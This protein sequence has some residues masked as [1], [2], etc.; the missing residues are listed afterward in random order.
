MVSLV[1]ESTKTKRG[2]KFKLSCRDQVLLW[3]KYIREYLSF[4]SVGIIFGVS[5]SAAY[6]VC[7]FVENVLI[8]NKSFH[9]PGKKELLKVKDGSIAIDVSESPVQRPTKKPKH[10]YSGKKKK[11]TI[12]N[13]ISVSTETKKILS[14]AISNCRQHDFKLFK[15]SKTNIHP[16]NEVLVDSGYQGITNFHSNSS[17]PKKNTKNK[18]LSKVDKIKNKKFSSKRIIVENVFAMLKR[19]KIIAEKY[20]NRR[21]RFALRFNLISAIYNLELA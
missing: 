21:K 13:Q 6:R 18:K 8:K 15:N 19:F 14:A 17:L 11:H 4:E 9:L 3:L 12:K 10:Y 16:D 5:K 1:Q 20:R 7:I 2:S